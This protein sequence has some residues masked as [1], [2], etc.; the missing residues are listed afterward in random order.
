MER[1]AL[2]TILAK[3]LG[4]EAGRCLG[5][6]IDVGQ[7]SAPRECSFVDA[8][9]QTAQDGDCLQFLAARKDIFA[10]GYH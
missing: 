9:G 8:L 5:I 4:V 1:D 2:D 10:D 7:G 3:R 6:K